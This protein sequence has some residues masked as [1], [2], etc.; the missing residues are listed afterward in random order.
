[1]KQ[2]KNS[3]LIAI[4]DEFLS[5]NSEI[6]EVEVFSVDICGHFFGKRYPI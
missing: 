3:Q 6:V 1:M 2:A 4:V 5:A